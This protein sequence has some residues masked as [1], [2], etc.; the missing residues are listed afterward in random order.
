MD[1][2]ERGGR[3]KT[4]ERRDGTFVRRR[5]QGETFVR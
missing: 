5:E 4:G 1:I 2:A 3:K